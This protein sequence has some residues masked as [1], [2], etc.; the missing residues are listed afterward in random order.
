MRRRLETYSGK[1]RDDLINV[2]PGQH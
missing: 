1:D 2:E